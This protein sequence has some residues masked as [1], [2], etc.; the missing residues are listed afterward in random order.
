MSP[1]A[2]LTAGCPALRFPGKFA[3]IAALNCGQP[4][5]LRP[6]FDRRAT[7]HPAGDS[8][9]EI[10]LVLGANGFVGAHLVAELSRRPEIR[11]VYAAVRRTADVAGLTR[12]R[13]T[14]NQYRV[15]DVDLDKIV[16]TAADLTQTQFG[17]PDADY[18]G[19]LDETDLVF[20]CA[21]PTD[22]TKSYLE[23]R[24]D[25]VLSLLRVLQFSIERRPKHLT[26]LGSVGSRC[27]RDHDDFHRPDSWWYSGYCQ[28]KWVNG[29]LLRG[30]FD[31]DDFHITLCEAP[32]I[33]GS[34]TVGLDPRRRYSWWRLIDLAASAGAIWNGPG[35]SYLPVDVLTDVLVSNAT[36]DQPLQYLLPRNPIGYH[37]DIF[38]DLLGLDMVDWPEF[39]RLVSSRVSPGY[40]NTLLSSDVD[41]LIRLVNQPG[42]A[43][44]PGHDPSWCDTR[45]LLRMYLQNIGIRASRKIA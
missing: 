23:L 14:F 35:M 15:D 17:L 8:D 1:T 45:S 31:I 10:A 4:Q 34:T 33:L 3:D 6:V 18:A 25:W 11:K 28:M 29:E 19:L 5:L 16:V 39:V 13:A 40:Q 32:Q 24:T 7:H 44:P 21:G 26:Y 36:A 43:L 41:A 12:L 22:H 42:A 30:L 9:R 2:A 27:Y 37:N 38:A 20:N